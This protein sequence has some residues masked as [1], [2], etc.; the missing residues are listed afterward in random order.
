MAAIGDSPN[1]PTASRAHMAAVPTFAVSF[2]AST[3]RTTLEQLSDSV[4]EQWAGGRTTR[5]S[6]STTPARIIRWSACR[7]W[8]RP[9]RISA[10]RQSSQSRLRRLLQAGRQGG[11]RNLCHDAHLL[12]QVGVVLPAATATNAITTMR[13]TLRIP[14]QRPLWLGCTTK[15]AARAHSIKVTQPT[16]PAP[17]RLTL[18]DNSG[19]RSHEANSDVDRHGPPLRDGRLRR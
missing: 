6:S 16:S 1:Q 3:R 7:P 17:I 2:P 14:T 18:G 8:R 4:R 15:S 12:M 10:F 11:N 5:P 19:C 13:N 9:I